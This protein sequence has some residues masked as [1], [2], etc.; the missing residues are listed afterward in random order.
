MEWKA[1]FKAMADYENR[2]WARKDRGKAFVGKLRQ[3]ILMPMAEGEKPKES[4]DQQYKPSDA[5]KDMFAEAA[6]A[7]EDKIDGQSRV[8]FTKLKQT[9]KAEAPDPG[10]QKGALILP[11]TSGVLERSTICHENQQSPYER[12][13]KRD[14]RVPRVALGH[15]LERETPR[16]HFRSSPD[17][18]PL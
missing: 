15:P 1:D 11:S 18:H 2:R 14:E 10:P 16:I 4:H 7:P 17:A 8:R 13:S 6:R 3:K 12:P 9:V 5:L